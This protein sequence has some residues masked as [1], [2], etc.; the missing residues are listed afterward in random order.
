MRFD[1]TNL[2]EVLEAHT[3]WIDGDGAVDDSNRADFSGCDVSHLE[4][5]HADLWGADFHDADCRGASFCYANLVRVDFINADCRGVNF[6]A[7]DMDGADLTGAKL[8]SAH[9]FRAGLHRAKGVPYIPLAC[10]DTGAFV[11][12]KKAIY[13][14]ADGTL[15]EYVVVKLLIPEDA[16]RLSGTDLAC[17]ASHAKVLE[18]QSLDGKVLLDEH[19][20]SGDCAV[21]MW[22]KTFEY[23]V[24]E[25]VIAEGFNSDRYAGHKAGI[26]FYINRQDAADHYQLKGKP[27]CV[28][29]ASV[30]T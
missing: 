9:M 11:G 26:Y 13:R 20:V 17:R 18:V 7:A 25:T 4:F 30:S 23:V 19:S 3:R 14:Y 21:S 27:L 8:Y 10:P 2:K 22:R 12:W 15:G 6:Y 16:E 29:A 24:G 1:G 28:E 5:N